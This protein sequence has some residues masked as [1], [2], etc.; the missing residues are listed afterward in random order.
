MALL[1]ESV[2]N[3]I[4]NPVPLKAILIGGN[5]GGTLSA[6]ELDKL[7]NLKTIGPASATANTPAQTAVGASSSE[8]LA[9]NASRVECRIAN[10]GTT[11]VYIGL[12]QGP[13][14]TAYHIALSGCTSANDGTGGV[15]ASSIF[16]GAI[17]AIA[18]STGTV[19]ITELT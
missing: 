4:G 19:C 11:V 6:F 1:N 16:K 12:G 9:A 3:A 18:A 14:M 2:A 17:N 13:T 5:G 10:T 7:G 8:V 15:Y